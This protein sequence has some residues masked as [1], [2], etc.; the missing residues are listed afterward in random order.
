MPT[1]AAPDPPP[2]APSPAPRGSSTGAL[3]TAGLGAFLL[4][5]AATTFV[6]VRWDQIPEQAK[7]AA[8]VAATGVCLAAYQ[9]LRRRFPVTATALFHLGVLLVPIDVAAVGV[10]AEAPWPQMLFAQG[11][12]A[13]VV[14]GVA[15]QVERSVVFRYATW[16]GVVALAGG[17]GGLTAA[18]AGLILAGLALVAAVVV[19][20]QRPELRLDLGAGAWAVLAGFATPLAAAGTLGLPFDGTL[21]RLG[22]ATVAPHPTAAVTGLIAAVTLGVVG[23]RHGNVGVVLTG[24]AAGF[25]GVVTTWVSLEPEAGSSLAAVATLGLGAQLARRV[26]ASDPFW[27]RPTRVLGEIGTAVTGVITVGLAVVLLCVPAGDWIDASPVLGLTAGLVAVSWL[28][29]LTPVLSYAALSASASVA[30]FTGRQDATAVSLTL[31]GGAAVLAAPRLRRGHEQLWAVTFVAVAPLAATETWPFAAATA[32]AGALLIA[33]AAERASRSDELRSF[34]LAM[35]SLVPLSAGALIVGASDRWFATGL[36]LVAACWLTALILDRAKQPPGATPIAVIPRVAML[37]VLLGTVGLQPLEAAAVAGLVLVLSVVDGLRLSEPMALVAAGCAAP[38]ALVGLA[39]DAGWTVGQASML[40]TGTSL[41]WLGLAG[42]LPGRWAPPAL[43]SAVIAGGAGLALGAD[44]PVAFWTNVLVIGAAAFV[45]GLLVGQLDV[46]MV[47]GALMTFGVWGRLT[48]AGVTISEAYV[49]PVALFLLVAG[50]RA[51]H[52]AG[53][54]SWLTVAPAVAL[55]G[56]TALFERFDGGPAWHAALAGAVGVVAVTVGGTWRLAGPLLVGTVLVVATTIHETLGVTA[57]VPTW[58]W[59]A[60]GGL[61]LLAAGFAMERQ[62]V[63]PLE[64]GRRLVDVVN[65][66]FT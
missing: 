22:L 39:L 50:L 13:T 2:L 25:V 47:G 10:W 34:E 23:A 59:L 61:T 51:R 17:I 58:A 14:F 45:V 24:V 56:G 65:D 48:L 5:A 29:A 28:V 27:A 15:A 41:V 1:S 31:L 64:S 20:P 26:C 63:G 44:D 52:Q 8:L 9:G 49:A 54:G 43:I 30:L 38:V 33:L 35:L 46:S 42:S 6:A 36:G 60:G 55:L 66:R 57:H 12:T 53:G 16:A 11:L 4:F 21:T 37:A 19:S 32:A 7:L 40:V 3:W 62:G 18:P